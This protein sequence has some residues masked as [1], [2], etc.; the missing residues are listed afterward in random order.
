LCVAGIAVHS[1]GPFETW[2]NIGLNHTGSH[3]RRHKISALE[4][5]FYATS[6]TQ[7]RDTIKFQ[8][9]TVHFSIQ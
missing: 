8:F 4:V 1:Q 2:A 7:G 9:F 5:N 3:R 6:Q